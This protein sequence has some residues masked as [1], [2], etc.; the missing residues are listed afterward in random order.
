[1]GK[2]IE[3]IEINQFSGLLNSEVTRQRI[4]DVV[5]DSGDVVDM[6]KNTCG[7]MIEENNK[8][9]KIAAYEKYFRNWKFFV[10]TASTFIIAIAAIISLIVS[11]VR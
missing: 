3:K 4:I 7:E 5:C 6:V 10:P 2:E 9:Q 11:L 1:M 8:T